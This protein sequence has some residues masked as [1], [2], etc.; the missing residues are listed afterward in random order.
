MQEILRR[1][2][3]VD[4]LLE[5]PRLKDLLQEAP[6]RLVVKAVRET[7][8]HLRGLILAS[9]PPASPDRLP[10]LSRSAIA[11]Q[12]ENRT[13]E[14]VRPNFRRVVNGTGVII[15]TNLGRSLLAEEALA[16]VVLAGRYYNNLEFELS[17]GRRGER[18]SHIE[19][20]LCEL[21]GAEAG[22]V[23]NNNAGAVLISLNTLAEGREVV[24]SRGELVEIGGSFRIPEVMARSGA[25]LVEVGTTNKTHLRDYDRAVTDQTALLM[26]VHQSNFRIVGFTQTVEAR[27]LA[28]L[29][30]ARGLPVME[31]LGS[32]SLVDFSV[33]GL[34]KEPTVQETVRAGVDVTTFSGDKLLGGPQAGIIVGRR[35]IIGQIKKNPLNRALRIDKFTLASLEATLRLYLDQ[36]QALTS[37]PTL[38]MITVPYAD[39][40]RRAAGLRRKIMAV[41]GRVL[42]IDLIDGQSRIGGGALPDEDLKTRLVAIRSADLSVNRLEVWFRSRPTPII[43]R[44]ENE[45][46]VLDVRTMTGDDFNLVAQAAAELA[47]GESR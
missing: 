3:S 12:V 15:H 9:A 4:Q 7:L 25:R 20:L 19:G 14:L 47:S 41:A 17:E 29:A 36:D 40:R 44:I 37:I 16:A 31:D 27:D 22:L 26:K 38:R 43:G 5:E 21:T 34:R 1:L 8:D 35:E 45:R 18:Y 30:H 23:V 24:V 28:D 10:D 13:R 39:L 32:G 6:R 11:D 33:H 46:L 2:P 42:E